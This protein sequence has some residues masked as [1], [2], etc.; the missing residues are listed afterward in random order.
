MV[1]MARTEHIKSNITHHGGIETTILFLF[2]KEY[3]AFNLIL[4]DKHYCVLHNTC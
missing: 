3:M 2:I 1:G 4:S